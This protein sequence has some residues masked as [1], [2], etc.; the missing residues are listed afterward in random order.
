MS[1][2]LEVVLFDVAPGQRDAFLARRPAALAAL[3]AAFP[4]LLD[5]RLAEFDDGTWIDV[6][7]W[8]SRAEAEA[9]AAGLAE[10]EDARAWAG[11]IAEVRSMRHAEIRHAV[12]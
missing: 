4:G 6:V 10:L 9:A 11:L 7:R 8:R 2:H 5:A 3:G 1:E 12:G